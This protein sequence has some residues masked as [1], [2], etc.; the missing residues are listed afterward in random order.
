MRKI[1]MITVGQSPRE[2]ILRVMQGHLPQEV[3]VLQRGA[4][5]L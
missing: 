3:E 2:D 1:G 5:E 4:L